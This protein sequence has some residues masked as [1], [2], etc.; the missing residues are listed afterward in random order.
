MCMVV[1]TVER[2][3]KTLPVGFQLHAPHGGEK[4]LFAIGS[5]VEKA[6]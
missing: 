5:D 4:T 1:G 6:L 2:E 3:G